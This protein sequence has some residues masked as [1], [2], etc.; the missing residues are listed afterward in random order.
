MEEAILRLLKFGFMLA[1][2]VLTTYMS[3]TQIIRYLDNNDKASVTF[4]HFNQAPKDRYPSYTICFENKKFRRKFFNQT[5]LMNT[6]EMNSSDYFKMMGGRKTA[7]MFF[8]STILSDIDFEMAT[9]HPKEIIG[10]YFVRYNKGNHQDVKA[11]GIIN[12][13]VNSDL[14][15]INPF[16]AEYLKSTFNVSFNFSKQLPFYKSYQDFNRI[17]LTRNNTYRKGMLKSFERLVI[18][19]R[20]LKTFDRIKIYTHHPYQGMRT[21]FKR[22]YAKAEKA[23]GLEYNNYNS[24]K[25]RVAHVSVL[26]KREDANYP[27]NPDIDD[28]QRFFLEIF[29]KISCI[30]PYWKIFVG[31]DV[32]TPYCKNLSQIK[33]SWGELNKLKWEDASEFLTQPCDKMSISTSVEK[34]NTVS[35]LIGHVMVIHFAYLNEEYQEIVNSK[36]FGLQSFWSNIGGFI[37]IFLGYSLLQIPDLLAKS[38]SFLKNNL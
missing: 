13:V 34:S 20:R 12:L 36:D 38:I 15:W 19:T 8:N 5:Y 4:R 35:K 24:I 29:R 32:H 31:K 6:F 37:G 26:R 1:C 27:C 23:I 10:E 2:L 18:W 33:I 7:G 22:F 11:D 30:P 3:I 9:T 28:D 16:Q 14:S 21:F 17:C 25:F